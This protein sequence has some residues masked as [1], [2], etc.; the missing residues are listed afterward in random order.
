MVYIAPD[1]TVHQTR[2]WS[3]GRVVDVFWGT[4]NFVTQFFQSLLGFNNAAVTGGNR[5]GGGSGGGGG[6]N[7]PGGPGGRPPRRIGTI[8]E[9]QDCSM[10]AGGG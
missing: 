10:P 7:G 8:K 2:P 5:R 6:G 3:L 1:G 4:V 9:I